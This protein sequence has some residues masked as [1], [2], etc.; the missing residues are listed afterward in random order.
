[1]QCF[2]YFLDGLSFFDFS[3]GRRKRKVRQGGK[4]MYRLGKE[5]VI[6]CSGVLGKRRDVVSNIPECVAVCCCHGGCKLW[7]QQDKHK[8]KSRSMLKR[9]I[10]RLLRPSVNDAWWTER[11]ITCAG[12]FWAARILKGQWNGLPF[13]RL[14]TKM[15]GETV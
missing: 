2:F 1:M 3:F 4:V 6:S 5:Q 7:K 15:W 13:G 10:I 14:A 11:R 12:S 8:R 9:S